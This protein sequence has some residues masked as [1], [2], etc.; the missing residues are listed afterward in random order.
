MSG[1]SSPCLFPST[2][3]TLVQRLRLGSEAEIRE[4]LE[5]LCRAYWQ[6]LYCVARQK[7]LSEHDAQDM[8]QGF[9]EGLLRREIFST[10]DETNGMLRQLLLRSF[11]NYC[12]QQWLRA[13]RLKRGGG[14][15][16]VELTQFFD[17]EKAEKYFLRCKPDSSMEAQYIRAWATSLLERS[18][19]AL[20]SDYAGRGWQERYDLLEGSLLQ[21]DDEMSL[22]Q[23]AA[24]AQTSAGALRVQLHR[25]RG[26]YREKI[27]HELATTLGTDDPALIREEMA[28]LFKA[29]G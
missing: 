7:G 25:M 6:P 15:E 19:Q 8:V 21:Q 20:R 2:R 23:I 4:A 13:N 18:L 3:W 28:V 10:A 17:A 22:V 16:H 29:F 14:A 5:T 24:R 27:E 1:S 11:D 12:G 9:F 26:H